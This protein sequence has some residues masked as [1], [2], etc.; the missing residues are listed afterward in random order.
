MLKISENSGFAAGWENGELD[1]QGS[2]VEDSS[3]Y[4]GIGMKKGSQ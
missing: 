1:N 2:I 3:S 4:G